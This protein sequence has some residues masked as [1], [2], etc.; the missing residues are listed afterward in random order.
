MSFV[1]VINCREL[2]KTYKV[3]DGRKGLSGRFSDFVSPKYRLVESVSR[4]SFSAEGGVCIGLLG[5]N[6]SGKS[7]LIKM[8]CGLL[9]P[10]SGS[11]EVLGSTPS[12]RKSSFLKEIG[13]VFGHKSSL[14]WDLPLEE[15]FESHRVMYGVLFDKFN[16][17]KTKICSALNLNHVLG[18]PVKFLSL[19]ERVKSELAVNLIHSPKVL[20][21]DEPTV[22]LDLLSKHEL[23][24]YLKHWI[25]ESGSV[26][27]LTTH[28]MVDVE[29]CCDKVFLIDNG[30]LHYSGS[31]RELKE[32]LHTKKIVE[33][34]STDSIFTAEDVKRYEREI[35]THS[36]KSSLTKREASRLIFEVDKSFHFNDL[37]SI[38]TINE[39]NSLDLQLRMPNLEEALGDFYR[40]VQM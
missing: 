39:E 27:L 26:V 40:G 14:W 3:R 25:K 35:Q 13:V 21:L 37:S 10:T 4:I 24:S 7:T 5:P 32:Q 17:Q 20:F 36:K 6:G 34:S 11:V 19:G 15:S 16:S 23:R 38:Q 30:S 29:N 33:I 9:H 8:L 1:P 12:D 2:S 28:D 18:R 31:Y 22:G